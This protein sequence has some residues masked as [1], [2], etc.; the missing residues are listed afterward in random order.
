MSDSQQQEIKSRQTKGDAGLIE[1]H[2][3]HEESMLAQRLTIFLLINSL[4][5]LGFATL[6]TGGSSN[7]RL[8]MT[9]VAS[10][11][12]VFC[13]LLLLNMWRVKKT[14]RFLYTGKVNEQDNQAEKSEYIEGDGEN[15]RKLWKERYQYVHKTWLGRF[16]VIATAD[17]IFYWFFFM[18]LAIWIVS[19]IQL[20]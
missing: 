18:F 1:R 10:V 12:I 16:S 5:F 7:H 6:Q 14:L 20:Y 19:L 11:G 9:A 2:A 8:L 15:F 17:N 4:L 3:F 13:F